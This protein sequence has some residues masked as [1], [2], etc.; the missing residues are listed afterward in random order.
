MSVDAGADVALIE[1]EAEVI[2]AEA[3]V[4]AGE[5]ALISEEV[6]VEAVEANTR[7]VV[8]VVVLTADKTGVS[9]AMRTASQI[10]TIT[11]RQARSSSLGRRSTRHHRR[12]IVHNTLS[13]SNNNQ[14]S[15]KLINST[16]KHISMATHHHSSLLKA[17]TTARAPRLLKLLGQCTASRCPLNGNNHNSSSMGLPRMVL[18]RLMRNRSSIIMLN[19]ELHSK[20][21]SSSRIWRRL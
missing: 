7:I 17:D 13:I 21:C 4:V 5:V 18:I 9:E 19:L 16:D 12:T 15:R 20:V 6:V 8:I 3:I 11:S 10:A 2:G 14:L 1:A